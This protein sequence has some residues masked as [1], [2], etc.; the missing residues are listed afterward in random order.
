MFMPQ[1]AQQATETACISA[2]SSS[3]RARSA[4]AA[5][6]SFLGKRSGQVFA[7]ANVS[8]THEFAVGQHRHLGDR[9]QGA[10]SA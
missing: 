1:G 6:Q 3:A 8:H 5:G 2:Q 10:D 4:A 9:I 7:M